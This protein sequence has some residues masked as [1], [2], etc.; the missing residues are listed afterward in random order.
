LNFTSCHFGRYISSK[1]GTGIAKKDTVKS[2][3]EVLSAKLQR[4]QINKKI[5]RPNRIPQFDDSN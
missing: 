2:K 1:N 3:I 4:H 5:A